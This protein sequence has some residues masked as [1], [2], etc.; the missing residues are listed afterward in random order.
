MFVVKLAA[1]TGFNVIVFVELSLQV[2][3]TLLATYF[4]V[5]VPGVV[6]V[7]EVTKG[8][9]EVVPS[10]KYQIA[11]LVGIVVVCTNCISKL[12]QNCVLLV[13]AAKGLGNTVAV[14]VAESLQP[15]EVVINSSIVYVPAVA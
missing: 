14:T 1:N 10:P 13:N 4:I 11:A 9:V 8:V 7:C 2:A 5:Y 12:V 6:Y 3:P 15:K